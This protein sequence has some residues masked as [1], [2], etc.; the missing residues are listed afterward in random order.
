GTP[1]YQVNEMSYPTKITRPDPRTLYNLFPPAADMPEFELVPADEVPSPYNEL[2]VHEH[3]MTVTVER[4]HG[5]LVDVRILAR[6]QDDGTYAR[7][8]LLISQKTGKIVQ[9]GIVRV[10]LRF[11][12]D[13]V[14]KE[15]VAGQSAV[16]RLL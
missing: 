9:F 15:L 2:L 4:H 12:S 10:H 11:C 7:K 1:L 8:I 13:A 16:G 14:R 6:H 5:S 3:H